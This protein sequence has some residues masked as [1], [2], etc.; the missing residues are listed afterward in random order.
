MKISAQNIK[1]INFNF[2]EK[3]IKKKLP[4]AKCLQQFISY[5][6]YYNNYPLRGRLRF[7]N[8]K[9]YPYKYCPMF[10]KSTFH[11]LQDKNKARFN[12]RLKFSLILFSSALI[13]SIDI[14]APIRLKRFARSDIANCFCNRLIENMR[15]LTIGIVVNCSVFIYTIRSHAKRQILIVFFV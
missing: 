14:H 5:W 9:I 4:Q 12:P 13:I 6:N 15:T 3:I 11:L 10:F 2:Q 8:V 1:N 7:I